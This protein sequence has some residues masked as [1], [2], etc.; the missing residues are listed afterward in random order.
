MAESKKIVVK[1][2]CASSILSPEP[3]KTHEPIMEW[4]YDRIAGVV[5]VLLGLIVVG[6]CF[7]KQDKTVPLNQ[8]SELRPSLPYT[9]SPAVPQKVTEEA[10]KQVAAVLS[11]NKQ[12]VT[13]VLPNKPVVKAVSNIKKTVSKVIN[14]HAKKLK[15]KARKNGKNR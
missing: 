13:T 2:N 9:S 1:V 4:R 11:E 14:K 6:V 12:P 15:S 5:A 7:V 8:T 3:D 10:P